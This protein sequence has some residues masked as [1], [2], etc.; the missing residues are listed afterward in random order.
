[1]L[2]QTSY[3]DDLLILTNSSFKDHLFKLEMVLV[4]ISTAGMQLNI[5]QSKFFA[6]QIEYLGHRI[7][8]QAI[9]L[10]N[11]KIE[12]FLSIKASK[13]SKEYH[14]RQFRGDFKHEFN[15]SNE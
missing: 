9:Q 2:R 8:R 4:R 7:T 12:A 10:I 3:L 1:M 5:S 13:T 11:I 14:L 6:V 15:K